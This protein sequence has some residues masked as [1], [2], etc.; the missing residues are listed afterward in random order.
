MPENN[1]G[2]ILNANMVGGTS[3]TSSDNACT[4]SSGHGEDVYS[5]DSENGF[6]AEQEL[7][8]R[9]YEENYDLYIDIIYVRWLRWCFIIKQWWWLIL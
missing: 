4:S 9:R 5:N 8:I 6:T 2:T 3:A 1:L 7:F